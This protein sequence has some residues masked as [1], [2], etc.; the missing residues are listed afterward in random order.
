MLRHIHGLQIAAIVLILGSTEAA[1]TLQRTFVASTGAD[2]NPCSLVAPCRSFGAAITQTSP[3]G[4]VIVLDSAGQTLRKP[5]SASS[6]I[7]LR[8][9][10][11]TSTSLAAAGPAVRRRASM[12]KNSL[13]KT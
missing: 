10:C 5:F 1:A 4:E 2:A 12:R 9:L 13:L 6:Y 3:G 11:T 8:T 7:G